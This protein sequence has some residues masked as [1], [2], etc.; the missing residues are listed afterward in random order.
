[1]LGKK[2]SQ[3]DLPILPNDDTAIHIPRINLSH[4]LSASATGGQNPLAGNG[5]HSLDM[6]FVVLQHLGDGGD[7]RTE[8]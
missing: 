7:F 6:R 3:Q 1:M 5:H 2:G 4:C 8:S